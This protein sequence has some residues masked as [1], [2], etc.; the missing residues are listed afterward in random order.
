[1][2]GSSS[3]SPLLAGLLGAAL[4]LPAA[5]AD[6]DPPRRSARSYDEVPYASNIERWTGFYLGGTLGYGWGDGRA[7]GSIGAIPFD[8]SGMVGTLLA[9]YNWQ[10]GRA[11]LG[12]E[13]D[14]G[15]GDLGSDEETV[16]GTFTSRLNSIGSFRGRAGILVSPALLVYGTAGLAWADMDFRIVGAPAQAETFLGWQV[17]LG[18][19]LMVSDHVTLRLEYIYTG[20]PEERVIHSGLIDSY[21]PSFGAVRAGVT[22][23]F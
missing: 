3:T 20:L 21:D 23:K 7:N 14:I 16:L 6:L 1:M 2:A 9:G 18:S 13:A 12:V 19:E 10:V 4:V 11:V 8:Q 17:G 5:A 22:F 15:I